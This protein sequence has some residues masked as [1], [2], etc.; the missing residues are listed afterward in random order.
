MPGGLRHTLHQSQR[1]EPAGLK[2]AILLPDLVTGQVEVLPAESRENPF[3]TRV[4]GKFRQGETIRILPGTGSDSMVFKPTVLVVRPERELCWRDIV[5][6][7][8]VFDGT[9]D[10]HLTGVAGGIHLKQTESFFGITR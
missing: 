9:R 1:P 3:I 5:W 8:G 6:I 4:D 10:I 7:R 2:L